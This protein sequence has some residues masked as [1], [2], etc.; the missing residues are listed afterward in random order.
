MR[1]FRRNALVALRKLRLAQ[2]L[3]MESGEATMPPRLSR[4]HGRRRGTARRTETTS[5]GAG[6]GD[7]NTTGSSPG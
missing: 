2:V 7:E 4:V 3:K 1:S 6:S 5:G